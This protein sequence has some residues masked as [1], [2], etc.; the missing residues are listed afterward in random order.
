MTKQWIGIDVSKKRLDIYIRPTGEAFSCD[1]TPTEIAQLVERLKTK[2]PTL[3]VL[4]ATGR[5]HIEAA[6]AIANAGIAIAVLNP[7]QIRDFARATGRLA[8]TDAIDAQILAHFA[9][10][11]QP[12]VRPLPSEQTQ[13]L[14]DL[15]TRR[16]QVV[17]ML[18]AEKNRLQGMSG[19]VREDIEANIDWLKKRL[20]HLEQQLQE[21]IEQAPVLQ[22]QDNLLQS[23]PGVGPV[24]ASTLLAELPEL[25]Q[26]SHKQISALV[27]VAPLNRDSGQKR[28]Q[29]STW[30]GRSA[31]RA[32]LY[33]AAV[34]G[35]R[36][37]PVIKQF[38]ERLKKAGK[39][40]KVV[41][42]ACMHKLLIILNAMMKHK[43][44]WQKSQSELT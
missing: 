24:V 3:V 37:N 6:T 40:A 44:L 36:F 9:E 34:V 30:G 21:L 16:H 31:I 1:N 32:A 12:S 5:L 38:Y 42:T 15:V 29:R 23:V 41:L 14:N 22:E 18:T 35:M 10:V 43:T 11:M 13:K 4:E 26:L 2:N 7:R 27:G 20:T 25:G 33:M 28:G 39:P 8:K 19:V 17:E